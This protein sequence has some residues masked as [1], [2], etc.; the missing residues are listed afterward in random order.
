M[1]AFWGY[2]SEWNLGSPGGW[3]YQ[4]VTQIIG[5]AVWEKLNAIKPI[6]VRVDFDHP[7][8]FPVNGFV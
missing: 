3:D 2:H 4:R 6:P 5:K 1:S 7:L 8:L